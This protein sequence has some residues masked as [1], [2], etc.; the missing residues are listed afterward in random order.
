ME[1]LK[2]VL[3]AAHFLGMAAIVGSFFVQ[4]RRKSDFVLT[5][6]LA[7]A[8]TQV[9][10]GLALVGLAEATGDD[11]IYAKIAVKLTIAVVVLVAAILAVVTQRKGGRVQPW[12]HAAGGLAVINVLVAVFWG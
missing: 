4:M 8:I 10:T 9:V 3:V 2:L 6:L 1:I 11:L 7:G 12:F 5:P